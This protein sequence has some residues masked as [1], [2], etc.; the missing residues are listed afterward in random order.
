MASI[1]GNNIWLVEARTLCFP[2]HSTSH[3]MGVLA[4]IWR[5]TPMGALS[6]VRYLYTGSYALASAA[7]DLYEDMRT[8]VLL[9][10]QLYRLGDI[11]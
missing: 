5:L 4:C 1:P 7:G 9:H 6:F 11:F 10:C 2:W 8:S 3:A